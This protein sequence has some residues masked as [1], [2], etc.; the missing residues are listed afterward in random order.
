[1]KKV[2]YSISFLLIIASMASCE[3]KMDNTTK[4]I[5]IDTTLFSGSEY[6]LKLKTFGDADDVATIT[7]QATAFS[8]SE[9]TN[10]AGT[11]APVYHYVATSKTTI[12]DHVVLSVTEGNGRNRGGRHGGD[13]TNITIN[14]IIK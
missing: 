14:F 7:K 5:V 13:S 12:S 10:T 3:K 2:I 11:F 8:T 6:V 4:Q 1:M 9:I